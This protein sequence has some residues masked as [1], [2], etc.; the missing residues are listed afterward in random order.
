MTKFNFKTNGRALPVDKNK[1]L[2]P[3]TKKQQST[4]PLQFL[5]CMSY[6]KHFL[7]GNASSGNQGSV[8]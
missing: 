1:P 7:L 4:M 3:P 5:A 8:S 2:S 6:H